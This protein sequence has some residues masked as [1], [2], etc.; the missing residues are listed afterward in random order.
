[1]VF[2]IPL[3]TMVFKSLSSASN[4]SDMLYRI[5]GFY[6]YMQTLIRNRILCWISLIMTII[7]IYFL[8]PKICLFDSKL[9]SVKNI[10]IDTHLLNALVWRDKKDFMVELFLAKIWIIKWKWNAISYY[11]IKPRINLYHLYEC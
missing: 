8:F 1:M 4:V 9:L 2:T 10:P 11:K 6:L 5:V 7:K 3:I